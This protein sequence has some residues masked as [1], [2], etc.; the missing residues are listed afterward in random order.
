MKLCKFVFLLFLFPYIACAQEADL[1]SSLNETDSKTAN[2]QTVKEK[3]K[4][5]TKKGLSFFDFSF[6][7]K[8]TFDTPTQENTNEESK[9]ET[10]LEKMIRLADNGSVDAQLSLGYMYLYGQDGV[11]NDFAKAFH[12]YKMAAAQDNPIALNNLGSLYF[13][14]I[15]TDINYKKAA[16]LFLKATQLGNDNAAVN[17]AFIYLSA[18]SNHQQHQDAIV[19]FTNAAK[20][21]NNT[22]KFMLGY[23]YYTGFIVEQNYHKAIV[24][25]RDAA[26]AQFDI[27]QYLLGIMYK[28]GQGITKN[29]GNA[30]KYLKQAAIQG[31]IPALME[32]AEIYALGEIYPKN[33]YFA[34]IYFNIASVYDAPNA[35]TKRDEIEGKLK[36]EMLL[37]AQAQAEQFRE[38]PSEI[39]SFIRTTYGADVR[40]YIDENLD[41]QQK[42]ND[43]T[44]PE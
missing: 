27:A 25:I 39:T 36:I 44:T 28:N 17:L 33:E 26:K 14:G 11:T 32:L 43:E 29:Y 42:V 12:Y 10:T 34:H 41:K 9:K 6:L 4:E 8:T 30:V 20:A 21:G 38:K 3:D 7:K 2:P 19:L 24:L 40:E 16:E 31:N 5:N 37:K 22:A 23:A 18:E 1:V 15:G 13:S 35:S